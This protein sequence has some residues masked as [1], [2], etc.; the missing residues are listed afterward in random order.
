MGRKRQTAAG[1]TV[2]GLSRGHMQDLR[3][4]YGGMRCGSRIEETPCGPIE[5]GIRGSGAPVLAVHGAGGGYDQG[6]ALA[7]T[8]AGEGFRCIAPSRF[9]YLRTPL[10]PDAS[11]PAQAAAYAGLLDVLRV[12]RA[13][14]MG[15]SAGAPSSLQFALQ[16]P[17][18]I[19][20]LVLLAPGLYAPD[21]PELPQGLHGAFMAA[22]IPLW[23]A[24][25]ANPFSIVAWLLAASPVVKARMAPS[26]RARLDRFVRTNLPVRARKAGMLADAR[27][28]R[29]RTR[30]PLE[31]IGVPTLVVSARDDLYA[32]YAAAEYTAR[33]MPNARF[34]GFE[35]GGHM[36]V[37]H[38][39][40]I[41]SAVT[42][43][44]RT[45]TV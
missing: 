36:L 9:G 16:Y 32:T 31:S 4:A 13:V 18:R 3:R 27:A 22:G 25:T 30:F 28:M 43:L 2:A 17:D 41:R 20:A 26:D 15:Y 37:G 35:R 12:R 38:E 24:I 8:F 11:I 34:I 6:I 33:S 45:V 1:A 29:F 10:P 42:G 5:Y 7:E 39:K 21:P 44:A 19:A 40:E 23:L 14:V